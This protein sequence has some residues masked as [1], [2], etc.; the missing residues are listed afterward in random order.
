[1]SSSTIYALS[2]VY[3]KS[4]VAV[5]RISGEEV[6]N[7][8]SQMTNINIATIK[9]RHAYF[10]DIKKK[11]TQELLDKAL[12]I[13]FKAPSSFTGEDIAEIQC[14]GSKAV[15]SS[16]LNALSEFDNVRLAE[17]GEFSKRSFY[18]QKM[19]LTEAE[20]LADLI[21]A[22]TSMQQKYALQ[23]MEGNLRNLY[24][25]WREELVK[26]LT[27]L[28]AFIDFPEED[29]PENL[30]EDILNTVFKVRKDIAK[31][32]QKN[33]VNERLRNGF[34]IVIA[35]E[36]NAGKSS[37][38]NALVKRN[39]VIVSDIAGTTRDAI[40]INLDMGGYPV[41]ITDTAG[42]RETENPIERQG[43][44]IAKE[45]ISEA[46]IVIAL[47]DAST[48]KNSEFKALKDFHGKV[49]YVANKIDK[50]SQENQNNID[51]KKH[52]K[53][54]A[55]YNQGIDFLATAIIETIKDNFSLSSN[56]L[57]T[58]IRYRDALEECLKNLEI[59]NLD[60]EIELAA[61]DI[62]LA[63]R[64]IG[65]ITGSVE[66]NEILNNI[67]GNFCIGK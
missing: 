14:H 52:I 4:G 54:S 62:R 12:V 44:E 19:D 67:F 15:L 28:E 45:K 6:L 17:P 9:Q 48:N 42:I 66:V 10:T 2:T 40:D 16:I 30:S 38:I 21:D 49:F 35:G 18:N 20:G 29:I 34:R 27:Y 36:T 39:A 59:F 3:G 64:A 11:N 25:S 58:R 13:Y 56:C 53:I 46:D 63:C 31:H 23:Q 37:L 51:A 32:L 55:K 22:E 43:I 1:M 41:I 7:I 60:K 24:T 33:N 57:I 65:K 5:I 61:E 50:V 8:I 26:V 47:Y